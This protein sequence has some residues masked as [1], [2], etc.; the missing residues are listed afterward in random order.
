MQRCVDAK[1]AQPYICVFHGKKSSL[2]DQVR[3][4][5]IYLTAAL[6]W[7]RRSDIISTKVG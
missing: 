2:S 3:T 5:S 4:W 7:V 1:G 6:S